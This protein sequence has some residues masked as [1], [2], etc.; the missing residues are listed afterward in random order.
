MLVIGQL[1]GFVFAQRLSQRS[2]KLPG[3]SRGIN[4]LNNLTS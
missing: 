4:N 3:W 1:T 2:S